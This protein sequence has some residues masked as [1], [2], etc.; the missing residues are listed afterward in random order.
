MEIQALWLNALYLMS[1][2]LAA[3]AAALRTRRACSSSA[4]FWNAGARLP[5]RRDRLRRPARAERRR[6]CGPTRF[7]RSAGCRWCCSRPRRRGR[8]WRRV[9]RELLTPG[10]PAHA[11]ARRTGLLRALRRAARRERDGAYHQGTVWPWLLGPFVE[12]W[13]RVRGAYAR[14]A[15]RRGRVSSSRCWRRCPR[16]RG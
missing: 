16:T 6:A 12:A 7:S 3:L 14:G 1:R 13:V 9:E 4:K 15:G 8:W 2:Q 10:G 5:L 11:R